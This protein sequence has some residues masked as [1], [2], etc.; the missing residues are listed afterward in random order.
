MLTEIVCRT[1][2][3]RFGCGN[4]RTLAYSAAEHGGYSSTRFIVGVN[5]ILITIVVSI[6]VPVQVCYIVTHV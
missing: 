6:P 5:R 2:Y 1:G 4:V 3:T